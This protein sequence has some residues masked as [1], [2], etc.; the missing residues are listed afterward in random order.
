MLSTGHDIDCVKFEKLCFKTKTL[1]LDL[2]SW[3]CM[4]VK[5]LKIFMHSTEVIKSCILLI[6][7]LSEES[8]EARNEDCRR[9]REHHTRKKLRISTNIDLLN[10]LLLTSD[11]VIN[12]LRKQPAKRSKKFPEEIP[13]L[14]NCNLSDESFN[15]SNDES[16]EDS[17]VECS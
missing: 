13:T 9:F 6:G 10:M 3:Y 15:V 17:S 4:P 1:D 14:A 7:Q 8:Q 2:Y 11:P 12:S 5:V 16:S